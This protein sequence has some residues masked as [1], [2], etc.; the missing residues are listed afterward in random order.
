M[1]VQVV[2]PLLVRFSL[3]RLNPQVSLVFFAVAVVVDCVRVI[4]RLNHVKVRLV[5]RF[6][7]EG[8]LAGRA[9]L[10]LG[11]KVNSIADLDQRHLSRVVNLE[12]DCAIVLFRQVVVLGCV[13]LQ[14]TRFVL[15]VHMLLLIPCSHIALGIKVGNAVVVTDLLRGG[16]LEEHVV[17]F[18][19]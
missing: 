15:V 13:A 5:D 7:W 11:H 8:D 6:V 1:R 19:I 12:I 17:L 14:N 18:A 2:I 3:T 4:V 10:T 9:R 16:V